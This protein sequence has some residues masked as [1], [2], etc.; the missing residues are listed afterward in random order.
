[1]AC[2]IRTTS[3]LS[4]SR[5]TTAPSGW[6][7]YYYRPRKTLTRA[8]SKLDTPSTGARSDDDKIDGLDDAK[9]RSSMFKSEPVIGRCYV[10]TYSANHHYTMSDMSL[11]DV[12]NVVEVWTS[13]YAAYLSADNPLSRLGTSQNEQQHDVPVLADELHGKNSGG[14]LRY[15]HIFDNN[16]EIVGCSNIH[17]HA[18][19]WIT[20][21][22]PDEPKR[23]FEQLVKY[24]A[25]HCGSHLLRDYLRLELDEKRKRERVVWEN[26]GFAV[27]CP[28]WAV[29]AFEVLLLPKRPIRGLVELTEVEKTQFAEAI[30]HITKAYD[31]LF[32]VTFPYSMYS[33]PQPIYAFS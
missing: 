22:L 30:L 12:R 3:V 2:A 23:E 19:I 28:W 24:R 21:S 17:P 25:S 20:S 8:V 7:R 10:L 16:G 15:M 32:G 14:L 27:L 5:T 18:Q 13:V 1:M 26:E 29:W 33:L 31:N 9:T 4:S 11:P 6:T